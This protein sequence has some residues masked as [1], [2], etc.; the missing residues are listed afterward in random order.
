MGRNS[1]E[2]RKNV[3]KYVSTIITGKKPMEDETTGGGE[4]ERM[5][6]NKNVGRGKG[7]RFGGTTPSHRGGKLGSGALQQRLKR[8]GEGIPKAGFWQT[9]GGRRGKDRYQM[10]GKTE[11]EGGKK[12]EQQ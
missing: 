6:P 4:P 8:R 1:A 11:G 7:K 10:W 3:K 12:N 5:K 9:G 2:K